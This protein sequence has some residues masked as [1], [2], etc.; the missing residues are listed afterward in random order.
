MIITEQSRGDKPSR[1]LAPTSAVGV[2]HPILADDLLSW[3]QTAALLRISVPA[4]RQLV[5]DGDLQPANLQSGPTRF[6]RRTVL[7][8][9][10]R[11]QAKGGA[12]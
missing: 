8:L 11:L 7:A 10:E 1:R 4:V 5:D 2:R 12:A 3:N 9:A 6:W